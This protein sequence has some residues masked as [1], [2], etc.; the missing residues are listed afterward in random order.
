MIRLI[1]TGMTCDHCEQAVHKALAAV[2]GV[3]RVL[4]VDREIEQAVVEGRPDV[5]S[6]IAAVA[7]EGYQAEVAK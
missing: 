1:I 7:A 5:G 2:Q 6:L 3:E 4:R